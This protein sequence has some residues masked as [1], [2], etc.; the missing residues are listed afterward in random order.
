MDVTI[1]VAI[2]VTVGVAIGVFVIGNFFV[3]RGCGDAIFKGDMIL[4]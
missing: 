1:D 3:R 2:G 4:P